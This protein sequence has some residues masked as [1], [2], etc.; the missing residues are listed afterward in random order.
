MINDLKALAEKKGDKLEVVSIKNIRLLEKEI[1]KYRTEEK[2]DGLQSWIL[3]NYFYFTGNKK[4]IPEKM[5]SVIIVAVP[6]PAY[7]NI[8]FNKDGK[9]YKIFGTVTSPM[10]RASKYITDAV[11]KAGYSI[12]AEGRM[13]LKRIAVQSRLAEYGRN[14][15]TYVPGMGSYVVYTGFSTDMPCEK[16]SWREA[17]VSST[18]ETCEI[19]LNN[20]PT[21]A[22]NKDRFLLESWKCLS[23]HNEQTNDFP[24]WLPQDAHHTPYDCLKCQVVCPLNEENKETIDV[25]F[26][27]EETKRILEGAPYK[28]VSKELKKKINLLG[29]DSWASIPRNLLLLFDLMDKGQKPKL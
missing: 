26:D 12:E 19:C 14:N 22:I 7:A 10:D 28:D 1:I 15:I 25:S 23:A 8:T 27:E 17:V 21:K 13:P 24:D 2:L 5:Q 4:G 3:N 29:L 6:H 18:C 11:K 9:E 20:C 16:D